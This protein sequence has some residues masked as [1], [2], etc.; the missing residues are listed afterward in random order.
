MDAMTFNYRLCNLE[1]GTA[2]SEASCQVY[3]VLQVLAL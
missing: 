2:A 3:R 1:K